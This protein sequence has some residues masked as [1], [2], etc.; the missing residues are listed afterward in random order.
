MKK[1]VKMQLKTILIFTLA[2]VWSVLCSADSIITNYSNY[3]PGDAIALTLTTSG[4]YKSITM[5]V[6][7]ILFGFV[8]DLVNGLT[9]S[10]TFTGHVTCQMIAEAVVIG[11]L[12]VQVIG[13]DIAT[14]TS[15]VTTRTVKYTVTPGQCGVY[16]VNPAADPA[17]LQPATS[18]PVSISTDIPFVDSYITL[19]GEVFCDIGPISVSPGRDNRNAS[20][21][22]TIASC[23]GHVPCFL[24]P[25]AHFALVGQQTTESVPVTYPGPSIQLTP[26]TYCIPT[27]SLESL[28]TPDL[29]DPYSP[30][31][32]IEFTFQVNPDDNVASYR[33]FEIWASN[34]SFSS[35]VFVARVTGPLRVHTNAPFTYLI[36][37]WAIPCSFNNAGLTTFTLTYTQT[38]APGESVLRSQQFQ[39]PIGSSTTCSLELILNFPDSHPLLF[40]PSDYGW[41]GEGSSNNTIA[42]SS[43]SACPPLA[44]QEVDAFVPGDSLSFFA[45]NG[46]ISSV[47]GPRGIT[48][49][50]E[51]FS[52]LDNY[53]STFSND[54]FYYYSTITG[55]LGYKRIGEV[56]SVGTPISSPPVALSSITSYSLKGVDYIWGVDSSGLLHCGAQ[57]S[58]L[59]QI[60]TNISAYL[61]TAGPTGLWVVNNEKELFYTSSIA[62]TGDITFTPIGISDV[63]LTASSLSGAYIYRNEIL[64]HVNAAQTFTQIPVSMVNGPSSITR[65]SASN[66]DDSLVAI[67][68]SN[69]VWILRSPLSEW[70]KTTLNSSNALI[71]NFD[72]L[73]PIVNIVRK[74]LAFAMNHVIYGPRPFFNLPV[75]LNLTL[76][77]KSSLPDLLLY[78]ESIISSFDS[79][80]NALLTKWTIPGRYRNAGTVTAV[81]KYDAAYPNG[82]SRRIYSSTQFVIG[83][84]KGD[85]FA[86]PS[87]IPCHY[88]RLPSL[89]TPVSPICVGC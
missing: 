7:D 56:G 5:T 48:A 87:P 30:L 60:D 74:E 31:S 53:Q 57:T 26:T 10:V 65:I 2:I 70:T 13:V 22:A 37:Q 72:N 14:N 62:C 6:N 85:G 47:G 39:I 35:S 58:V 80:D 52:G 77:I 12:N 79:C 21:T 19:N 3:V 76:I 28:S 61:V 1:R 42:C 82:T 16:F 23:I 41:Y 67:D 27:F 49:N 25:S 86:E 89:I 55:R 45:H 40:N 81:L 54:F 36:T 15:I 73:Y 20:G 17:Q 78:S 83:P 84:S 51:Y 75:Y 29:L 69:N 24:P 11:D 68:A 38:L 18:I 44:Y 88:S 8:Q 33:N 46:T 71:Y 64:Y 34:L 9:G 4:T 43:C 50:Y 59:T 63:V 66:Q 32:T